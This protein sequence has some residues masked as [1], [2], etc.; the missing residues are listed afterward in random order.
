MNIG[1]KNVGL[2]N[3]SIQKFWVQ[4]IFGYKI[5]LSSCIAS[6]LGSHCPFWCKL[7]NL[8]VAINPPTQFLTFFFFKEF[9]LGPRCNYL[10]K[11]TFGM[12]GFYIVSV[13]LSNRQWQDIK[14]TNIHCCQIICH[15]MIYIFETASKSQE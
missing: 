10:N 4:K 8:K 2:K 11:I 13:K 14:A 15:G 5:T 3:V 12:S 7:I 9:P 1:P 6:F